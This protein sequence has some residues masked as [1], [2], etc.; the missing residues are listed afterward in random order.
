VFGLGATVD[1]TWFIPGITL[2]AL[3]CAG[4]LAGR[5]PIER[6]VGG[7]P[8]P[9]LGAPGTILAITA[10]AAALL[11]IGWTIFQPL[12]SANSA[13]AALT[14]ATRGDTAMAIADARAAANEDPVAV[15]PLF[16]LAQIYHAS[17]QNAAA[18]AELDRAI[19]RQPNNPATWYQ[20]WQLLTQL[21]RPREA[22]TA[23]RGAARLSRDDATA[24]AIVLYNRAHPR[25][26]IK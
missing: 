19:S 2:P 11:V 9:R 5:G 1:W 26:P 16:D 14:A 6:P 10:T 23:L 25:H 7:G 22:L 17:G 15:D 3:V 4:W 20:K 21:G 18:L 12:R 24:L 13:A 8:R